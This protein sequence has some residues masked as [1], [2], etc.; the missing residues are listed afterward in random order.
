[1]ILKFLIDHRNAPFTIK[2]LKNLKSERIEETDETSSFENSK[3]IDQTEKTII[4][5]PNNF[6]STFLTRKQ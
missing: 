1:M 2:Q 5:N 4:V 6:A 3:E